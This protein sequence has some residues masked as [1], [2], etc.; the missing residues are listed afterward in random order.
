MISSMTGFGA[1]QQRIKKIGKISVELRSTNHKFLDLVC[2]LPEGF[3]F[4]EERLKKVIEAKVKR[5]RLTCVINVF[6]EGAPDVRINKKLLEN[7]IEVIKA[8]RQRYHL[9]DQ[10][11]LDTLIKLPGVLSLGG[12]GLDKPALWPSLNSLI[13]KA[14]DDLMRMRHRE[15]RALSVHL[16]SR[17]SKLA[18][19]ISA[20]QA[21]FK[22]AV[23]KKTAQMASDE[24][25][26][27]FIKDTDITEELERLE[28]H[29]RNFK[30]KLSKNGSVG[31]ELDFIAQ[32]MQ[33]EA[34]TIAAKSCDKSISSK[35]IQAKSQIE[36]IRE[37]AQNI[38]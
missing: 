38:E 13:D 29:I 2:H 22:R 11:C 33:R 25:R 31:K 20:V 32:E 37:Q 34:N 14:L 23:I 30:N 6:E 24:E 15:G 26:S 36:K 1:R 9:N 3:M 21:R 17:A 19:L 27:S 16:K 12:E 18:D 28:F 4:L 35:I 8:I 7:Y 10:M 5:G